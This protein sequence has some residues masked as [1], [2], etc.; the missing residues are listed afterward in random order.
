MRMNRLSKLAVLTVAATMAT[1]CGTF[2]IP[3]LNG[4]PALQPGDTAKTDVPSNPQTPKAA[5]SSFQV[6]NAAS[7][8]SAST[9][10]TATQNATTYPS[11]GLGVTGP[12]VLALNERL[13]ELGYLPVQLTN[14]EHP[15]ISLDNLNN[16]PQASFAWRYSNT[17]AELKTQWQ[18]DAYTQLT[19]AAV[20]AFEHVNGLPVDGLTG[21]QVW[22]AIL[23]SNARPNPHRYTYVL[24]DKSPGPET[25][26]V[27]KAGTWIYQ[28]I[29]NTGIS[30]MPTTDG[31][32]AVYLRF[33]S[34]TMTGQ[35]P[36][37][38]YYSD[39]G[40]PYVNYFDGSQAIHGF[41]RAS[42]GFPQ[43]LGCVELPIP[44]SQTVWSLLHYGT[45]VTIAGHYV[46]SQAATPSTQ[47]S[48]GTTGQKTASTPAAQPSNGGQQS[49]KPSGG[50]SQTGSSQT[51][52]SKGSTATT[53]GNTA[54]SKGAGT[55][56][57][58]NQPGSGANAATTSTSGGTAT[59]NTG[60]TPTS[61]GTNGSQTRLAG[62]SGV[63]TGNGTTQSTPSTNQT[64]VVTG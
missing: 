56:G 49:P 32:Y 23:P 59:N 6:G 28:S 44:N 39:K 16:P 11:F 7:P 17:P 64:Q 24:V 61:N 53:K 54:T 1:G 48:P 40:V 12:E 57:T 2:S 62:T 33:V 51:A 31:T 13:A 4:R 36:N 45:P 19:R 42:Y 58:P 34:Q 9:G 20:I 26:H 5:T 25:I 46:P 41:V 60:V 3:G 38:T 30:Q 50:Q 14:G 55:G 18:A 22:Q 47:P 35:N 15:Q 27:W 37:G 63:S 52:T 10:T 21:P 29:C 8:A 43:S